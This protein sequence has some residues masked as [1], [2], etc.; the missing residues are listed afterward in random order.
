MVCLG[1]AGTVLLC[2]EHTHVAAGH[3]AFR[4]SPRA[5]ELVTPCSRPSLLIPSSGSVFSC[6]SPSVSMGQA[7]VGAWAEVPLHVQVL[8]ESAEAITALALAAA[9][10]P[11]AQPAS[12]AAI[13]N[14]PKATGAPATAAPAVG[15]GAPRGCKTTNRAG[16]PLWWLG[17]APGG[18]NA[19]FV[20]VHDQSGRK[21]VS[22]SHYW[23]KDASWLAIKKKRLELAVDEFQCLCTNLQARSH[24]LADA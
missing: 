4:D 12:S 3:T 21:T 20:S 24:R 6:S 22:L 1:N 17:M 14:A 10:A 18:K 15:E 9:A 16:E 23:E 11:A 5:R 2:R 7:A 19:K 13:P 8:C